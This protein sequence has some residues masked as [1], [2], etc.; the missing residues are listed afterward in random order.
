MNLVVVS[1][2]K[3]ELQ[4]IAARPDVEA[5]EGNFDAVLIEPVEHPDSGPPPIAGIGV[6]NSLRAINAHRV[7]EEL[8]ITGAGTLIGSLDTG[9]QGTHPALSARWRGNFAPWQE[10]WRD[11]LGGGTQFPSD[12]SGHGTHTTGT[13]CG[14]GHA[15]GDTVGVAFDALWIADNAI[16]QGVGSAFDNDVLDAFQWFTDPDGNPGTTA[17]VPDVVQNSWGIDARFGGTYQDCDFRWQGVI[18]NC[19]AAG[20][21]VTFSSGNEGPGAQ[22]HRSPANIANSSTTNFAV[23][24]VD[25]ENFGFPYPIASFSSRGPSDCDGVS[26]KPEVSAP[27]VNVYSS[28]PGSTYALLSGTSMA[29]PHVAGVVALM[30]QANPN[31]DVQTIKT[32]LMNTARDEGTVGQDNAYGWGVIDAYQAV[33]A[34]MAPDAEP[35]T[36]TVATPNGGEVLTAGS[37]YNIT[38]SSADNVGVAS[39]DIAYSINGGATYNTVAVGLPGS[40][41]S[42]SWTVPNTPSTQSLVRVTA[43]DGAGNTGSDVSNSFFTIQQAQGQYLWVQSIN[44]TLVVKGRNTTARATVQVRDQNGAAAGSAQVSSHWTGLTTDSDVFTTNGSGVGTCTS[45]KVRD[46]NGCWSYFVDNVTKAG[47]TFRNDLGE[48][49]DVICTGAGAP[50]S[51][52]LTAGAARM[53]LSRDGSGGITEFQIH[54]PER[55]RVSVGVFDVTGRKVRT[56]I[57]N[58]LPAGSSALLWDGTD[59]SGRVLPNGVY[60]YRV[61]LGEEAMTGKLMLLR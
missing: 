45:N 58:E 23:G 33:L 40:S 20:V 28:Y 60:L 52:P 41:S 17:D 19:E 42:Y 53:E 31:A 18:D 43:R 13:M 25:A 46:A 27:G 29:G 51:S 34:V 49:S 47:Y 61:E 39:H 59:E 15:T 2:T 21:V 4:R 7:W 38:W 54:L 11:A 10:C 48:T 35:P 55:A 16:N 36:V 9:V 56:L 22:T 5:I 24:A 26:I 14:A 3:A 44:L 30:R 6:T 1:A 57:D 37:L 32:V 50:P 8:G 12:G